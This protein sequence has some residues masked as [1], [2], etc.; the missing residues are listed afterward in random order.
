MDKRAEHK[1]NLGKSFFKKR[2]LKILYI[3]FTLAAD[4]YLNI[5]QN[6]KQK[7]KS[8]K[9]QNKKICCFFRSK[10]EFSFNSILGSKKQYIC[11]F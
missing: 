2:I 4:W 10:I 6:L 9:S 5:T 7:F 3:E 11:I 1:I 8:Q